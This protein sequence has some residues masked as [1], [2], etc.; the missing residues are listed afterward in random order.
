MK[1]PR[2][3]AVPPDPERVERLRK[4]LS[5]LQQTLTEIAHSIEEKKH[6]RCPYRTAKD[7]CTYRGGCVNKER[8]GPGRYRC[9][10][11]H[12]LRWN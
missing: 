11:D 1:T 8:E 10:G 5:E 7:E 6:E 2:D 12:Q 9:G 3:P 4:A